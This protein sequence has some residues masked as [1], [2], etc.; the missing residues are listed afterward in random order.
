MTKKQELQA[1]ADQKKRA[2]Q[3]A[4]ESAQYAQGTQYFEENQKAKEQWNE[5]IELQGQANEYP[6]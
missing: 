4:A 5:Y 3:L 6:D 2:A 1:L